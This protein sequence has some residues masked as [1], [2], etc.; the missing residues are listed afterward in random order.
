MGQKRFL[1]L[2]FVIIIVFSSREFCQEKFSYGIKGGVSLWE[3]E[4]LSGV[5]HVANLPETEYPVGYSLG[6]F[7]ENELVPNLSV[8]NE[9]I[10][11][12][13]KQKIKVYT[14]IEG[15]RKQEL[16]EQ[17][18]DFSIL[19]KYK[20]SLLWNTYFLMGPSFGYLLNVKNDYYV[21]I[22]KD[23]G[24]INIDKELPKINTMIEFGIGE[25]FLPINSSLF[26]ELK[27]QIGTTRFR[28]LYIGDWNNLGLN[29]L[30]GYKF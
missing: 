12:N 24:T 4:S 5:Q 28:Y 2:I 3:F 13:S 23:E 9:V 22:N 20:T 7:I 21:I 15:I 1:Y 29:I 30:F 11:Q 18:I 10:F 27:I 26:G 6:F 8:V 25:E 19:L 16:T 14:G 17:F